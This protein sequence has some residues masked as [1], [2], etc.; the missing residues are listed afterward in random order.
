M[1]VLSGRIESSSVSRKGSKMKKR[2]LYEEFDR[3]SRALICSNDVDPTYPVVRDIVNMYKFDP[4]WFAFV[5][6]SF[7]NL[8]SAIKFCS[9]IPHPDFWNKNAKSE[10][11]VWRTNGTLKDFGHERR[12]TNRNLLN[13]IKIYDAVKDLSEKLEKADNEGHGNAMRNKVFG[14]NPT[15]RSYIQKTIPFHG[16]WASFKL[17]EIFEKSYC[18]KDL[19][20]PDIGLKDRDPNSNDG[21]VGGLRWLYGRDHAFDKS[22]FPVWDRFAEN[23]VEAYRAVNDEDV[24]SAPAIDIGVIETCFCKYHKIRS[25]NYY[26]GHDIH[27]FV[28]LKHVMKESEYEEIMYNNFT[29]VL[30]KD[31]KGIEK[32]HKPLFANEGKLINEEFGVRIGRVNVY[33]ILMETT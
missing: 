6:V 10:F 24:V 21:P 1:A 22:I 17:A 3:F 11:K 28:E 32:K 2:D 30:W 12:G 15:F 4:L 23:L 29:D 27:E 7:Y 19:A 5:Y 13:Q 16:G 20:I 26:I 14:D 9:R 31:V 25:G 8:S 18:Y 33:E